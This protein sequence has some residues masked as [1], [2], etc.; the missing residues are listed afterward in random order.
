M[1][2]YQ[3][4]LNQYDYDVRKSCDARWIDQKCTYDVVSIIADCIIEFVDQSDQQISKECKTKEFTVRDIWYSDYARNNVIAIFSKPDPLLKARNE[5]D[6]YFGQPI[7]L[8]SYSKV[9]NSRKEGNKYFYSINNKAILEKIA[10]RPLNA[11]EFL[12]EYITKVLKDSGIYSYFEE[13]FF[14][15]TKESYLGVREKFINFTIANTKINGEQECGRIFAKVIN[16]LAFKFRKRGTVRGRISKN[17][18]TLNDLSYNKPNWRDELSGKDKSVTRGEY[19]PTIQDLKNQAYAKYTVDKA[20]KA[21]KKFNKMHNSSLSEV[22]QETEKLTATQAHHIFPQSEYPSIADYV[23]NLI[24]I[25]PNQHFSMAHPKNNTYYVDKDFQYICLLAKTSWICFDLNSD[26]EEK[27]YDFD[28]YKYVLNEGLQTDAF[29]E[30]EINDFS[31]IIH[32]IDYFYSDS[33]KKNK[34]GYLIED[35]KPKCKS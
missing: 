25:T 28:D 20:K 27:F 17:I 16:P 11:L 34:Y 4:H 14:L 30:I 33:I 31:M 12:C 19:E 9:L 32:K 8:L 1:T 29:D 10:L 22:K 18:I 15:Q 21:V 6:K 5:Y 3:K 35:N 7:K 13:F 26:R 24:M 2:I 23:E